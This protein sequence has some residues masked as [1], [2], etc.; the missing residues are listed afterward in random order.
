M[1]NIEKGNAL[2]I[3]DANISQGVGQVE[4]AEAHG[5]YTFECYGADGELKWTDTIENLVLTAGKNFLLDNGFAGSA[6]TATWFLGLIDGGAAPTI[7]AAD[8]AASHA[9]WTENQGY[10]QAARPTAAWSAAAAGAKALSAALAF[11]INAVTQT[12]AGSF[13]ATVSTKGGTTGVIYS[14]GT[15]TGGNKSVTTGDTLNVSYSTSI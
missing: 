7:N 11:S 2:N 12:I 13:L 15:F 1:K 9:G 5:V 6:Y 8:T 3:S 14:A 10:S 4:K